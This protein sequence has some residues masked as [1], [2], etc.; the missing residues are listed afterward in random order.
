MSDTT[1]TLPEIPAEAT[2]FALRRMITS[3][4]AQ[5]YEPVQ[6][7]GGHASVCKVLAIASRL[8]TVRTSLFGDASESEPYGLVLL[9]DDDGDTLADPVL[10]IPTHQA[11]LWWSA[12]LGLTPEWPT[13]AD[14][15]PRFAEDVHMPLLLTPDTARLVAGVLADH[16]MFSDAP[17]SGSAE[18][19][20]LQVIDTLRRLAGYAE[21]DREHRAEA[22]EDPASALGFLL[23]RH[24]RQNG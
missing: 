4:D 14:V 1:H 15:D 24:E 13:R 5:H 23:E 22:D 10:A 21:H 3:T 6:A 9:V 16:Q 17:T 18:L 11:F 8:A 12:N 20:L 7:D 19:E 2:G